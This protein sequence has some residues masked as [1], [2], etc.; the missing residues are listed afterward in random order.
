MT[1]QNTDMP[2]PDQEQADSPNVIT[3]PPIIFFIF[4]IMGYVTDRAF[5]TDLGSSETRYSIGGVLLVVSGAIV[6]WA[7]TH[8]IRAK[9]H[10]DV[11]KPAIALVT[12]GPYRFSR[13]PMY[14]AMTLL[15]GGFAAAFSLPITL[16]FLIPCLALLEYGVISREEIYLDR[17]FGQ[18]YRNYKGRVRRW[19]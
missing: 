3:F 17:K 2:E 7:I 12:D 14:L 1:E 13:N 9:T 5:P 6:V 10:V 15:Y 19:F 11:R 4:Y 8:F 16:G 18:E